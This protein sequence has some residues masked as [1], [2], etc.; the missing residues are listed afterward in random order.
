MFTNNPNFNIKYFNYAQNGNFTYNIW[1]LRMCYCEVTVTYRQTTNLVASIMHTTL[2]NRPMSHG[3]HTLCQLVKQVT[4]LASPRSEAHICLPLCG[5]P[6]ECYYN[7]LSCCN[8]F[9]S[10]S[11]LCMYSKFGHHPHP[12]GYLCAK[13]RFFHSLYCWAS[14]WRKIAYSVT[15]SVTHALTQL[16]WCPGNRSTCTS[17]NLIR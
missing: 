6:S 10:S 5:L 14:P 3:L 7:T 11:A 16:I 17:E 12:L 8:Y 1:S 9:A 15:H 4:W 2:H 13:L